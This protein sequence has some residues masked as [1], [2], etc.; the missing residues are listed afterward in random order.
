MMFADPSD[1]AVEAE[2]VFATQTGAPF[3]HYRFHIGGVAVGEYGVACTLGG[4]ASSLQA[5]LQRPAPL[6]EPAFEGLDHEAIHDAVWAANY[7]DS[8][9]PGAADAPALRRPACYDFM[10]NWGVP[11]DHFGAVIVEPEAGRFE[12]LHRPYGDTE[13]FALFSDFSVFRCTR[14]GVTAASAAFAQWVGTL[15]EN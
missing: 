12:V 10:T 9:A 4:L 11:F 7:G 15:V 3:G 8:D 6:W 1:F 5:F 14:P 2:F 13:R